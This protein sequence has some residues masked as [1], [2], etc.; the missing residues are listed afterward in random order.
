MTVIAGLLLAV[1]VAGAWTVTPAVPT[2]GD[3]V[4]FTRAIP[5]ATAARVR[6]LAG[7]AVLEVLTEPVAVS[8]RG[9]VLLRYAVAL[10][11][12][13]T[14]AVAMPDADVLRPDGVAETLPG[15]TA[16]VVIASV[17]PPEDS[18]PVPRP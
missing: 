4:I 7:T 3:T 13:G 9:G 15:D 16:R 10:F 18:L 17:L 1:Q 6:P 5:G 8:A 14:H 11:T 2:V 12:A